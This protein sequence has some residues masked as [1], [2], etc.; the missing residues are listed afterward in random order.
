M[1]KPHWIH[2]DTDAH[3]CQQSWCGEPATTQ[4]QRESTPEEADDIRELYRRTGI[5]H[6]SEDYSTAVFAC[7]VHAPE[8][9]WLRHQAHCPAPDEGCDCA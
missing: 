8:A 7:A 4:W 1:P 5:N 3:G 6:R 9:P 2:P